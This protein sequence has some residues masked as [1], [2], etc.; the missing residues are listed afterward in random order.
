MKVTH[1]DHKY[2]VVYKS[3]IYSVNVHR[4]ESG[5][6]V[7]QFHNGRKQ[8]KFNETILEA[9]LFR[10]IVY[11]VLQVAQSFQAKFRNSLVDSRKPVEVTFVETIGKHIVIFRDPIF[12]VYGDPSPLFL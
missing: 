3:C 10:L 1:S 12:N 7:L 6:K 8:E 4:S 2:Q 5:R 9:I 11:Q